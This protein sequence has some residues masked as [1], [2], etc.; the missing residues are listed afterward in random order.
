MANAEKIYQEIFSLLKKNQGEPDNMPV[1][2][3]GNNDPRFCISTPKMRDLVSD[4][5][6][7]HKDL[8]FNDFVSLLDRLYVGKHNEEKD[9]A[10]KLLERFGKL[11]RR[12]KPQS[13]DKWLNNLHGWAQIDCLCGIIF[14]ADEVLS[15]WELWKKTIINFSKDKNISKR[16]ASLV[17]LVKPVR[18]SADKRLSDLAFSRIDLLKGEKDILITKAASWLLRALIKNHRTEVEKYLVKNSASLP[19]I[20]LRETKKKLETGKK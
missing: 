13:I 10:S 8:G 4:F 6:D 7:K 15:D 16:R 12:I 20:A 18:Q 19:K 17:L 9:F 2:Y 1:G 5:F 3:L 11:R 14:S